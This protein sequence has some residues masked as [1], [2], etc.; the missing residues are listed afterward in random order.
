MMRASLILFTLAVSAY[1]H[2]THQDWQHGNARRD[3]LPNVYYHRHPGGVKYDYVVR[4]FHS[5]HHGGGRGHAAAG[6]PF[7][8]HYSCV[9]DDNGVAHYHARADLT[10]EQLH[11]RRD[12]T[13]TEKERKYKEV[14]WGHGTP[15]G[16]CPPERRQP[17]PAT[18][19][20]A[21]T[22]VHHS[23]DIETPF[24]SD[25][26]PI[27][28]PYNELTV[29]IKTEYT[30]LAVPFGAVG[31]NGCGMEFETI[32]DFVDPLGDRVH[33][34]Y[35]VGLDRFS[36]GPD[37]PEMLFDNYP[38][39]DKELYPGF[40]F[41]SRWKREFGFAWSM[42]PKEVTVDLT[43][44]EGYTAY[45]VPIQSNELATLGDFFDLFSGISYL[46]VR[47]DDG[48]SVTV[49]R[50]VDTYHDIPI[51]GWRSYLIRSR[52]EETVTLTGQTW[53]DAASAAPQIEHYHK[54]ALT[55]GQVKRGLV[56][57]IKELKRND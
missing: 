17:S 21:T 36:Y 18:R 54:M 37:V 5:E 14:P 44:R 13:D 31:I 10:A 27:A 56:V 1:G 2:G 47:M 9:Y 8:W 24:V 42:E 3:G 43:I 12:A 28:D 6:E 26:A 49:W 4:N 32:G 51:D 38:L 45:A 39:E 25:C 33:Y 11:L 48:G 52:A 53:R 34:V 23:D 35:S 19:S 29:H 15:D 20:P 40:G 50:N 41:L 55:W 57:D 22:H 30:G 16:K 46:Y 7:G